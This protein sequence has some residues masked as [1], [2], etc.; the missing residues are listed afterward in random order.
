MFDQVEYDGIWLDQ[1]EATGYC[2]GE[3][4]NGLPIRPTVRSSFSDE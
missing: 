1:N 3:C 4:P 2:D